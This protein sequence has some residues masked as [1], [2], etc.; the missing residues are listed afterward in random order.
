[1]RTVDEDEVI[2]SGDEKIVVKNVSVAV[3]VPDVDILEMTCVADPVVLTVLVQLDIGMVTVVL[4]NMVDVIL[5]VLGH[6]IVTP[7]LVLLVTLSVD[8]VLSS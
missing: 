8:S 3:P 4:L 5:L 2:R 6:T 1:M 7:G